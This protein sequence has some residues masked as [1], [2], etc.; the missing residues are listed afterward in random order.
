MDQR[1]AAVRRAVAELPLVAQLVAIRIGRARGV[2]GDRDAVRQELDI[3]LRQRPLVRAPQARRQLDRQQLPGLI[4][5]LQGHV[6]RDLGAAADGDRGDLAALVCVE[7]DLAL[8]PL[9]LPRRR[10]RH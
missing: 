10:E 4:A 7:G 8:A 9:V 2:E 3:G 1:P 5:D 6:V